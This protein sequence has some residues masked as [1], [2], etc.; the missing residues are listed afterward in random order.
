[1]YNVVHEYGTKNVDIYDITQLCIITIII[2]S[3]YLSSQVFIFLRKK[4]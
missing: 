4:G 1:M 3:R 2:N